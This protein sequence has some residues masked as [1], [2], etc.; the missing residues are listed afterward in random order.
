[1]SPT[2]SRHTPPDKQSVGLVL[3]PIMYLSTFDISCTA[4]SP[5]I[6]LYFILSNTLG[7][8]SAFSYRVHGFYIL[9]L[10]CVFHMFVT[11]VY[12]FGSFCR[13]QSFEYL[14][15]DMLSCSIDITV[16]LLLNESAT[17]FVYTALCSIFCHRSVLSLHC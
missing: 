10:Y 8:M 16:C 14:S 11:R 1:M 12:E 5:L 13:S 15:A 3:Y 4:T 7:N 6:F 9:L 2:L 17:D